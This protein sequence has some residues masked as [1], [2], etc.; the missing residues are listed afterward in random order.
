MLQEIIS[1]LDNRVADVLLVGLLS[2][3]VL[4][5]RQIRVLRRQVSELIVL[6]RTI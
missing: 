3:A 5:H 1:L 4:Q 6:V 2:I